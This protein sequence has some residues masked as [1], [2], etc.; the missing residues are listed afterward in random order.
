MYEAIDE[1]FKTL[2]NYKEERFANGM[3]KLL[4]TF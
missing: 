2:R 4:E 1:L 3:E